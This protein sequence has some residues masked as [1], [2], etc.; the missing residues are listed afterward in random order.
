MTIIQS[1]DN[2]QADWNETDSTDPSYIQNKPSIPSGT[3]L[4][5]PVDPMNLGNALR[6]SGSMIP[7]WGP[8]S[9]VPSTSG[10]TDGYVL[11]NDNGT[12]S[13][14]ASSGMPAIK[15]F[16]RHYIPENDQPTMGDLTGISITHGSS[17][18]VHYYKMSP[19]LTYIN[20]ELL[21]VGSKSSLV[22]EPATITYS[23]LTVS[24]GNGKTTLKSLLS[25][26]FSTLPVGY[27]SFGLT[28]LFPAT[29]TYYATG[30]RVLGNSGTAYDQLAINVTENDIAIGCLD[31]NSYSYFNST[32]STQGIY[33]SIGT[34]VKSTTK[35]AG[36]I[37]SD[38][39]VINIPIQS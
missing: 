37:I 20:N 36:F 33:T 14:N 26:I 35:L 3:Q 19:K 21:L 11:T 30:N 10:V 34:E 16:Y 15:N 2:V 25:P 4:V 9:E 27:Y 1:K 12:P 32:L 13:W 23:R 28:F 17:S 18:G 31:N 8:V 6:V 29:T 39:N 5:P 38:L 24:G 22:I 7:V